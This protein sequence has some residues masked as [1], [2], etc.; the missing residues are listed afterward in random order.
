MFNLVSG[1][2]TE[3]HKSLVKQNKTKQNKTKKEG[4]GAGEETNHQ[5]VALDFKTGQAEGMK[6]PGEKLQDFRA[7]RV[8]RD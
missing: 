4:G 5:K 8:F 7:G 3:S 2:G 1:E 6:P